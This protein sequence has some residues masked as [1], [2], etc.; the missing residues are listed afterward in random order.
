MCLKIR[1][2]YSHFLQLGIAL[3]VDLGLAQVSESR[4]LRICLL[5][6]RVKVRTDAKRFGW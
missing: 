3:F 4:D 5:Q 2:I 6:G 1:E